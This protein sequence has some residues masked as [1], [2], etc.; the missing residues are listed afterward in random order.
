MSPSIGAWAVRKAPGPIAKGDYVMFTLSHPLAGPKPVSVTKHALC[1]PGD[2]LI[3]DRE[4]RRSV[5]PNGWDGWYFCNGVLLGVSKP[6][7]IHG[8]QAR[9]LASGA[10]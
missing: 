1:M 2:R 10:A 9:A 4:H 8:Q 6:Y 3:T 5:R 7:G